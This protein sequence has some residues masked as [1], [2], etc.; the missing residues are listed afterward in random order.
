MNRLS[1]GSLVKSP[2]G[3]GQVRLLDAQVA[4]DEP[5]AYVDLDNGHGAWFAHADLALLQSG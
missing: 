5:A 3:P 1:V 2:W 4:L